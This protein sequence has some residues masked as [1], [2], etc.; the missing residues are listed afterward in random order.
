MKFN[1]AL[2]GAALF[3]LAVAIGVHIRG[4]PEMPGQKFGA[5]LFPGLIAA[6]LLVCGTMLFVRGVRSGDRLVVLVPWM[7]MPQQVANFVLV[8]AL[9]LFYIFASDALGFIPSGF[10]ILMALFLKL[11]VPPLRA[12]VVAIIA[13]LVIHALFYKLLRVPLPWGV[14]QGVAW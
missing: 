11:A 2:I 7:R 12:T 14:L 8:C 4:F 1:D 5:A 10:I 9:L 3:I 6:G 13:T